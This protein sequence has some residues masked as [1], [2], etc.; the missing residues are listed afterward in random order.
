MFLLLE[1]KCL[2]LTRESYIL[3]CFTY[4]GFCFQNA[5]RERIDQAIRP[6]FEAVVDVNEIEKNLQPDQGVL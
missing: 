1:K 6:R 3:Q 4:T 5:T 2:L